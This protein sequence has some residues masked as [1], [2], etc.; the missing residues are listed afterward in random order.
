MPSKPIIAAAAVIVIIALILVFHPQAT[1]ITSTTSW[2]A[3]QNGL[4]SSPTSTVH[5]S[6]Q[7]Y[8]RVYVGSSATFLQKYSVRLAGIERVGANA[9]AILNVSG[10]GGSADGL[11]VGQDQYYDYGQ[12]GPY[13]VVSSIQDSANSAQ[14]WAL[15]N[16]TYSIAS[17]LVD[18]RSNG[19]YNYQ[20]TSASHNQSIAPQQLSGIAFAGDGTGINASS[21]PDCPSGTSLLYRSP[22]NYSS[23]A[24]IEGLGK[25]S[26]AHV[27]PEQADH[28]YF[29][30]K[31]GTSGNPVPTPVYAPGNVTVLQVAA[32]NFPGGWSPYV[33][34]FSP[35]KSVMFAY[36]MDSVSSVI[37]N[38]L[39][40]KTLLTCQSGSVLKNC[41]YGVSIKLN[42][43][44]IIGTAGLQTDGLDFAAADVRTPALAWIDPSISTGF[45]GNSSMHAV[46]PINYFNNASKAQLY[47]R[48][49]VFNDSANGIPQCGTTMQDAPGTAQGNWYAISSIADQKTQGFNFH[50]ALAIVHNNIDH[51][52]GEISMG[53]NNQSGGIQM[54]FMPQSSGQINREPNQVTSDGKIYCYE[55]PVGTNVGVLDH[56][57]SVNTAGPQGHY[58]IKLINSTA[59]DIDFASGPCAASP[60]LSNP[61]VYVR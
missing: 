45:L 53:Q 61:T 24:A 47:K 14:S 18:A 28:I 13:V 2:Q 41:I 36:M 37:L 44:D 23:L 48:L 52:L 22:I 57:V 7:Q 16:I 51:G 6:G 25:M 12:G 54:I 3:A 38:D 35:C 26:G 42:G 11:L 10:A 20:N 15:I 60:S 43:S 56:D 32:D 39:S 50:Y 49:V 19:Y 46:C 40:N 1:P 27:I 30:T 17:S 5:Q 8:T 55:G 34:F 21:L 29:Y 59:L 31:I 58:D 33:V 9:L 4:N